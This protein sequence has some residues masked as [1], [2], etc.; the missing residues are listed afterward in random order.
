MKRIIDGR[1]YIDAYEAMTRGPFDMG[2]LH[3]LERAGKLRRVQVDPAY[4]FYLESE[5]EASVREAEASAAK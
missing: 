1:T 4:I 3:A 5:F 2:Q